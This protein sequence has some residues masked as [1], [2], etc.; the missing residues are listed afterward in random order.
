[1][2]LINPA[3]GGSDSGAT[4]SAGRPE[5]TYTLAL[6]D[7]LQHALKA[8]GIQSVFTRDRDI[9]LDPDARAEIAN[10]ARPAA[11]ILL[12]ATST[13]EGVHLFTSSLPLEK[14][15]LSGETGHAFLPWETVQA[16]YEAASL[17]LEGNINAALKP[18]SAPVIMTRTSMAT[19]NR[20]AC[21]AVVVELAPLKPGTSVLNPGYERA[22]VRQLAEALAEWRNDWKSTR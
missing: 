17:Q 9:G 12:H 3:H 7:E 16:D 10:R 18:Q 1:L 19:L 21:P 11:C 13:G 8:K 2:V 4:L 20:L 5:K 6:A 22:I 15:K 14:K